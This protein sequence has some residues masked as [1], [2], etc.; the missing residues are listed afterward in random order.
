MG[1]DIGR[2]YKHSQSELSTFSIKEPV[3]SSSI[4]QTYSAI[5][6]TTTYFPYIPDKHQNNSVLCSQN[7]INNDETITNNDNIQYCERKK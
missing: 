6:L 4:S 1:K 7:T 2:F 5:N 3:S